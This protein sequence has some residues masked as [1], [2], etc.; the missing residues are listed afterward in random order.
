MCAGYVCIVLYAF[1]CEKNLYTKLD[2]EFLTKIFQ[3]D[4]YVYL[5]IVVICCVFI[6]KSAVNCFW[7]L[8]CISDFIFSVDTLKH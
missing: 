7:S 8:S 6:S 3:T 1:N 5:P 2:L 4:K